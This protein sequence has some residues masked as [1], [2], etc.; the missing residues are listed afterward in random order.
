MKAPFPEESRA[1]SPSRSRSQG[2]AQTGEDF[3]PKPS[4]KPINFS[5]RCRQTAPPNSSGSRL[6]GSLPGRSGC[7]ELEIIAASGA[8]LTPS[9]PGPAGAFASQKSSSPAPSSLENLH[10]FSCSK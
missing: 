1:L 7:N 3:C 6:W 4:S 5:A 8:Q 2:W 10:P 9:L